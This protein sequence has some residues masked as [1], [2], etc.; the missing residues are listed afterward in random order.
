MINPS[1][2]LK[3]THEKLKSPFF[4]S[5]HRLQGADSKMAPISSGSRSCPHTIH[6]PLRIDCIPVQCNHG[7][8]SHPSHH[9]CKDTLPLSGFEEI[10]MLGRPMWQGTD[11]GLWPVRNEAPQT[12]HPTDLGSQT[13]GH[14]RIIRRASQKSEPTPRSFVNNPEEGDSESFFTK[15]WCWCYTLLNNKSYFLFICLPR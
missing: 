12:L 4:C 10:A 3:V 2:I 6:T 1:L 7:H 13:L 15:W 9:L 5:Y 8:K 14:T 11:G